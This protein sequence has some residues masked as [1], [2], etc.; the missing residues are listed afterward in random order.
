[1]V[2][3]PPHERLCLG[4]CLRAVRFTRGLNQLHHWRRWTC[5]LRI[6]SFKLFGETV[7]D[8]VLAARLRAVRFTRVLKLSLLKHYGIACLRA[9][10]FTWGL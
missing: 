3:K 6:S 9:V 10:R 5:G 4:A 8:A 2:L 7:I 1:M